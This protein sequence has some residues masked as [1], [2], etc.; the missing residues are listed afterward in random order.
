MN[1]PASIFSIPCLRHRVREIAME[2]YEGLKPE[3]SLAKLLLGNALVL[4]RLH[5]VF[6][7]EIKPERKNILEAQ[8]GKWGVANSENIFV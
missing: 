3:K 5:V 4:E 7:K 2:N 1:V 6:V 8:M